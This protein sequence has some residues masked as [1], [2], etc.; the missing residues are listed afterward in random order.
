MIIHSIIIIEKFNIIILSILKVVMDGS[1][2]GEGGGTLIH[3]EFR[4][5]SN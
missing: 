5:S 2:W 4:I 1:E 3:T